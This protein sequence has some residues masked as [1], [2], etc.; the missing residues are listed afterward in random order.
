MIFDGFPWFFDDFR[1]RR[2][3]WAGADD[4]RRNIV[5]LRVVIFGSFLG[6]NLNF[7]M[8]AISRLLGVTRCRWVQNEA[9]DALFRF[10]TFLAR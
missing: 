2:L 8:S 3:A 9:T 4:I 1:L 6:S 5:Y 7:E 10:L